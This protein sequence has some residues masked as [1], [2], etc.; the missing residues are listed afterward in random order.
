MR[1][2]TPWMSS[3]VARALEQ[4]R[5]VE[6]APGDRGIHLEID[7]TRMTNGGGFA[8]E[9]FEWPLKDR[10]G[11]NAPPEAMTLAD[12]I[13]LEGEDPPCPE[14]YR[15]PKRYSVTRDGLTVRVEYC[16]RCGQLVRDGGGDVG[17]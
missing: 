14:C 2:D 13:L 16:R 6:L 15:H 3:V 1:R 4:G 10:R 5:T 12:E 11:P 9:A 8:V 17:E 7:G